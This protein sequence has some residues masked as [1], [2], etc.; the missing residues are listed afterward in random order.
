MLKWSRCRMPV[1]VSTASNG[2]AC[3]SRFLSS[4]RSVGSSVRSELQV[5]SNGNKISSVDVNFI[6]L[7]FPKPLEERIAVYWAENLASIIGEEAL[8]LRPEKTFAEIFSWLEKHD[9]GAVDFV[10]AVLEELY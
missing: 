9:D 2:P 8:Q 5:M 10:L 6:R 7:F 1:M 4:S 3:T